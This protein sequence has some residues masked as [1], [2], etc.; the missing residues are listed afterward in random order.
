MTCS[1]QLFERIERPA[2]TSW[3]WPGDM[4]WLRRS[5]S[6]LGHMSN[7]RSQMTSCH[8]SCRQSSRP[9]LLEAADQ[10]AFRE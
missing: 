8:T 9:V 5:G 4:H 3:L 2:A 6:N 7:G 10:A 1:K